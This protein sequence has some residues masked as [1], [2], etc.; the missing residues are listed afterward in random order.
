MADTVDK[1]KAL[2]FQPESDAIA[3][4]S[5]RIDDVFDR[6]GTTERFQSSVATVLDGALREAEVAR[7][8]E[9]SAAI[10]PLIVK[11]VKTEIHNSTDDLVEALYPAT[12]RMVKAYVASAIK[13]LTDQINRRLETN[14]VVLR[15]NALFSGR[16]V[17]ELAIAQSQQLKVEDVLLIRRA[18]GEL[19]ARAPEGTPGSNS[20]SDHVLGG[21]LTAINEFTTEAFKTEGSALRQIDLGD[22]RIYLRVSPAYLLAA[23]CSGSA[24]VAAESIFDDEFLALM[25]RHHVALEQAASNTSLEPGTKP[26]MA[27][28][29]AR[30]ETRL[31]ALAA[32]HDAIPPGIKPLPV[33][34]TLILLPLA[35]WLAWSTFV[36][37]RVSRVQDAATAV[38]AAETE[39]QGYPTDIKVTNGG[40][41]V[42][43]AGLAPALEVKSGVID[44]LR[45]AL[46]GVAVQDQLSPVPS[47]GA[48]VRPVITAMKQDQAAFAKKLL[49]EAFQRNTL[50]AEVAIE[51]TSRLLDEAA[52]QRGSAGGR[53]FAGLRA[54][55]AS[56]LHTLRGGLP[57]ADLDATVDRIRALGSK[58]ER[59]ASVSDEPQMSAAAPPADET[60]AGSDP[61]E[62]LVV[63]AERAAAEAKAVVTFEAVRERL[64]RYAARIKERDDQRLK[65][66]NDAR[67]ATAR[68]E[69]RLAALPP[70][71]PAAVPAPREELAAFTR[72][73]AVFF[74]EQTAY[75]DETVVA[76]TL[77]T[78][79]R[80]MAREPSM[81]IR[82]IGFTDDVGAPA[83]NIAIAD[84]RAFAVASA[85]EARGVA[86]NRIVALHRISPET[87][88]SPAIGSGSPNRRVEFEAG[89]IGEGSP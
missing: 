83:K 31:D 86:K 79:A 29:A 81:I 34:A 21:I 54:E 25:D 80:I 10:A 60:L 67:E 64:D 43:V 73:H 5:R 88:V 28:L 65:D 7:H 26:L 41:M 8:E 32:S 30:L 47:G 59:L 22:A 14:P 68:L 39:M 36:S 27:D 76:R 17:G 44:K 61:G 40:R 63:L 71:P 18:T 4:L 62:T 19:L 89:F 11:T 70:P 35:A 51:R 38:L 1:L 2:L 77:D 46:P 3:T 85:L 50:R 52:H 23:K 20:G 42:T 75:R 24:P 78:L 57:Q 58:I 6:A 72:D 13:D 87:Y 55:A 82:V 84:A 9:M 33:L 53:D 69:A 66:R 16:S 12:G 48:D 37:Y 45:A 15:L 49:T 74:S 56:I